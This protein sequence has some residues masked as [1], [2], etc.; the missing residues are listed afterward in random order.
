MGRTSDAKERIVRSAM[1]LMH[2]G[3]YAQAGVQEICLRAGVRK[4]SFYHFFASKSALALAVIARFR[5]FS[6]QFFDRALASDL[7]PL[8]RLE[9]L[10]QMAAALQEETQRENGFVKGCPFGNLASEMSGHDEALRLALA[11]TF[12]SLQHRLSELLQE[13]ALPH[14]EEKAEALVSLFEGAIL[15]AK[16][17]N[18]PHLIRRMA[19]IVQQWIR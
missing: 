14:A 4:G 8:Q 16:T 11:A 5:L 18:D 15:L 13:A 7:P 12:T 19:P 2:A 17:H 3:G 10:F 9:R 1:E 6:D